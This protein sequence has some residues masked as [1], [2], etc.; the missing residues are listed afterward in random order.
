VTRV[1][2]QAL[3]P[4]GAALLAL[5][6]AVALAGVAQASQDGSP[7]ANSIRP[8]QLAARIDAGD[9]PIILD[10]RT[11]EEFAAGHIPGAINIPHDELAERYGELVAAPGDEIVVHCQSGRRASAAE[12]TLREAGYTHVLDLKGHMQ[13]W[14]AA[15]LPIETGDPGE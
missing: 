13:G 15:G 1:L 14:K 2:R 12:R 11:R 5:L 4:P 8:A 3:R 9:A 10:V 6:G 7:A